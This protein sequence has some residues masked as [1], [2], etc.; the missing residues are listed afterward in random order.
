[1]WCIGQ[2]VQSSLQTSVTTIQIAFVQEISMHQAW[3]QILGK[4]FK[5]KY[6]YSENMKYKIQILIQMVYFKY[7]YKYSLKVFNCFKNVLHFDLSYTSNS[8]NRPT[9]LQYT[10]HF[11]LNAL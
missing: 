5:Y 7:K 6:K 9:C 11:L 8:Y 2:P 3:G 4:V 1:M 10:T